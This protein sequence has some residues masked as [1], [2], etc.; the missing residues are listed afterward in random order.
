M[1]SVCLR[2]SNFYQFTSESRVYSDCS[3][4]GLLARML[5]EFGSISALQRPQRGSASS[6]KAE[7]MKL[8]TTNLENVK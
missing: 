3:S 6:K 5:E 7:Q 4:V 2:S 1:Y 8:K